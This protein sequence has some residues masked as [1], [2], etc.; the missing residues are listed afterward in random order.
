MKFN[1][2]RNE[3]IFNTVK[4]NVYQKCLDELLKNENDC[5]DVVICKSTFCCSE[6]E[7]YLF[8]HQQ[9]YCQECYGEKNGMHA[10]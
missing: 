2:K 9:G 10:I 6:I 3:Y 1:I 5:D 8:E 7:P 4:S